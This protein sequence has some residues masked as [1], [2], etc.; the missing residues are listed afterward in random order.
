MVKTI[1]LA[2]GLLTA[3]MFSVDDAFQLADEFMAV[4][5][6]RIDDS[7]EFVENLEKTLDSANANTRN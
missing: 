2:E 6:K 4:A 5:H 3:G 1:E 7:I